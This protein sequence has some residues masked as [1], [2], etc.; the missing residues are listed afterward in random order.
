MHNK[1]S[2]KQTKLIETSERKGEGGD[3]HHAIYP[4]FPT[5]PGQSRGGWECIVIHGRRSRM[6]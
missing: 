4:C 2:Q 3:Y 1:R 5:K 6:H